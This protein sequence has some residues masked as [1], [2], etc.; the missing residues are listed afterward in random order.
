V[1]RDDQI[2]GMTHLLTLAL[3]ML[4][5]IETQVRRGLAQTGERLS[6]LYEGQPSR[7]TDRPTGVGLLKALTLTR[8]EMGDQHFWHITTTFGFAGADTGI[9]GTLCVALHKLDREFVIVTSILHE[10]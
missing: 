5:Q 7:K 1:R 4:T 9:S 3:R 10:R 2:V 6:G 8:V